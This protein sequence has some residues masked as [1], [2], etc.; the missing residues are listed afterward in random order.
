MKL[1][2][3]YALQSFVKYQDSPF[4]IEDIFDALGEKVSVELIAYIAAWLEANPFIVSLS[5]DKFLNKCAF[6]EHKVF[7]IAPTRFEINSGVLILGHRC[8]PFVS[9][10]LLPQQYVVQYNGEPVFTKVISMQT[11]EIF[12]YYSLFGEEFVAQYL[13]MDVANVDFDFVANNFELPSKMNLTVLD[14]SDIYQKNNFKPGDRLLVTLDNWELGVFSVKVLKDLRANPFESDETQEKRLEWFANF[15]NALLASMKKY[16]PLSSIEE[17]IAFAFIEGG[18]VLFGKTCG[19]VEEFIKRPAAIEIVEYGVETRLWRKGEDIRA[20]ELLNS[21]ES[22]VEDDNFQ[23]YLSGTLPISETLLDAMIYDSLYKKEK[24]CDKVL[25]RIFPD[26]NYYPMKER[27]FCLLHLEKR[28]A[29][30]SRDYNWFA[31][32]ELGQLRTK[33]IDLYSRLMDFIMKIS[34]SNVNIDLLPQQPLVILSQLFAHLGRMLGTLNADSS[35]T[36]KDISSMYLSL[37]GMVYTFEDLKC[38][39]DSSLETLK[40]ERFSIVKRRKETNE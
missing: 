7:S 37:D 2:F 29:I 1:E 32:Y 10:D 5:S 18:D 30:I 9:P 26:F 14:F 12:S 31:D 22:E 27:L 19:S 24:N 6:F 15:E 16:G 21:N 28:R 34:Q 38:E 20:V 25:E 40:K 17:Q 36:D 3:E 13:A 4:T 33:L 11:S 35:L 23:M 39:L 8:V